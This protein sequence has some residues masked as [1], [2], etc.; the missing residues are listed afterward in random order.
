MNAGSA[1]NL[2][3]LAGTVL[4]FLTALIGF[5]VAFRKIE[6]VHVLVNSN[7]TKVME[8]LGIEVERS[9][10]LKKT[11]EQAGVEVPPKP[12]GGAG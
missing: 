2:L 12:D 7:L 8:K 3:I 4:T 6:K 1:G 11:L 9:D 5:V 10:Q